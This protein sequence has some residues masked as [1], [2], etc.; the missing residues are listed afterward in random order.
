MNSDQV[1]NKYN[2]WRSL[3]NSRKRFSGR[4]SIINVFIVIVGIYFG[5]MMMDEDPFL[6]RFYFGVFSEVKAFK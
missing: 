1:L 3:K 6:M 2:Q 4:S 5:I